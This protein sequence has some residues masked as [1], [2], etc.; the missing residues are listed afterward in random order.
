[1]QSAD[2]FLARRG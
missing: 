2:D 1:M